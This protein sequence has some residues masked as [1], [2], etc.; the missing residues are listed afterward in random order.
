MCVEGG[1]GR[2][3][4]VQEKRKQP[5][6]RLEFSS[7]IR[8]RAECAQAENTL[9]LLACSGVAQDPAH[10]SPSPA[11]DHPLRPPPQPNCISSKQNIWAGRT[12]FNLT[13]ASLNPAGP[14]SRQGLNE[15]AIFNVKPC[16]SGGLGPMG[17]PA[18]GQVTASQAA[19]HWLAEK[20][21]PGVGYSLPLSL[22][23]FFSKR[24][25]RKGGAPDF[26]QCK[27][28]AQLESRAPS[29]KAGGGRGDPPGGGGRGA[30]EGRAEGAPWPSRGWGWLGGF[31]ERL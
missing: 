30:A 17:W 15:A 9:C 20:L 10:A 7:Y 4:S 21:P 23:P 12:P 11:Q 26:A 28:V 1:G 6:E 16:Q 2:E 14:I 29:G 5:S 24:W 19:P 18:G 8:T 22:A 25:V 31:G 27:D 13:W 3:N